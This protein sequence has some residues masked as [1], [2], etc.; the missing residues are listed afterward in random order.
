MSNCDQGDKRGRQRRESGSGCGKPR[1]AAAPRAAL[2]KPASCA[3]R[4][5]HLELKL[6]LYELVN[7]PALA[8]PVSALL[9]GGLDREPV[10]VGGLAHLYILY[11]RLQLLH[12]MKDALVAKDFGERAT[13]SKHPSLRSKCPPLSNASATPPYLSGPP[14]P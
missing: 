3:G 12:T 11:Q 2:A 9:V 10:H 8:L 6:V 13:R 1:R 4:G 5:P 14:S 7:V